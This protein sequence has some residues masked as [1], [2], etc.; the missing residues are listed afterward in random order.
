MKHLGIESRV[1]E[2]AYLVAGDRETTKD[3]SRMC[4]G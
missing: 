3:A 1:M 2:I 4:G